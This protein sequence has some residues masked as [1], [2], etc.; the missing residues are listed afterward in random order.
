MTA[1]VAIGSRAAP[2]VG[3]GHWRRARLRLRRDRVAVV[4]GTFLLVLL[5]AVLPGA[6]L[7]GKILGHG[8][9]DFFPYAVNTAL[10][11]VGPLTRVPDTPF[12]AEEGN[13]LSLKHAPPPPGTGKTLFLLG[14]DGRLGRDEFLRLLYGGRV[15]LE[16]AVGAALVALLVGSALGSLAGY[17]GGI[18]DAIVS[19]FTDLVMRSRSCSS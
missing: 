15:S 13:P 11:P 4:S 17:Y 14:A 9:N 2:A 1:P 19:R 5:F 3:V 12:L 18:V 16:V 10:R 8:P 7:A 6:P